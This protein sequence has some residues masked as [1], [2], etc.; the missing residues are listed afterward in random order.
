MAQDDKANPA[1]DAP[2]CSRNLR[3]FKEVMT[4]LE[5]W[6]LGKGIG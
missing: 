4:V 3:R 2:I 1:A 5:D 6:G